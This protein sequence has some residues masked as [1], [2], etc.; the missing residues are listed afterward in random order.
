[1]P[2]L[3]K[4][5]REILEKEFAENLQHKVVLIGFLSKEHTCMYCREVNM[6]LEE[7][8]SLHEKIE[9]K[10]YD[11]SDEEAEK[12]SVKQTPT[13]IITDDEGIYGNRIQFWGIPSG[14]EFTTLIEDIIDV[15][16]RTPKVSEQTKEALH[17]L[18]NNL[19]IEVYITPTCPYC[20]RAVRTA[21]SFAMVNERITGIMVEAIEFPSLA[22]R[23]GVMSV[24]HIVIKNLDK[25]N[26]VQFIGAYPEKHF[27]RFVEDADNGEDYKVV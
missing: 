7:V 10:I 17:K 12:Y 20:P 25:G 24:P 5:D 23:W 6:L 14:Y 8:S 16:R 9:L 1:M 21:H 19:Q 26:T 4:K 18:K 22:D 3:K 27:L 13:I 2:L 11:I 15:S